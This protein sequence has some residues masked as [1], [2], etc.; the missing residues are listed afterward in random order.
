MY[1]QVV[2][3]LRLALSPFEP[4][5]ANV[6]LYVSARGLAT[7]P[8][9]F[10]SQIF[11]A[12]FDFFDQMLV[13]RTSNGGLAQVPLGGPVAAFYRAVMD[14]LAGLGVT[15]RIS[16]LP[17]EIPD[18]IP[19]PVDQVHHTYDGARARQFW[20]VVARIDP[21]MKRYRAQFRGKTSPVQFFW[22][23]FDLANSRY[24]GRPAAPPP[25]AGT[26][27]RYSEDAE[28]IC[29]GFWAGDAATPF[30][31]FYAYGYPQPEGIEQ[32]QL[33]PDAAGWVGERG[34]FLLPYDAVRSSPDPEGSMLEFLTSSYDACAARLGWSPDLV[35]HEPPPVSTTHR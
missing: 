8:I 32:A 9:P 10:G 12:E 13:L 7:S 4:E 3:K 20:Q 33:R 28:Q 24:S 15:A 17:S 2:G 22:G 19:F 30:A 26:I 21:V 29:A 35:S 16:E 18:A 31:A 14:S 11:D 1:T 27:M 34:L 6:P 5:W 25:G 23:G